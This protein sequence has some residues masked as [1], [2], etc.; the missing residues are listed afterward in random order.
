MNFVLYPL[1]FNFNILNIF[2]VVFKGRIKNITN[3]ILFMNLKWH[4]DNN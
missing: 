1:F 2:E 4:G 3:F